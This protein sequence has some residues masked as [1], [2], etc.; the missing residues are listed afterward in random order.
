[1]ENKHKHLIVQ[2]S[3]ALEGNNYI[4]IYVW[5]EP[6]VRRVSTSVSV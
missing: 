1:M 4:D 5:S 6:S 2:V 3:D